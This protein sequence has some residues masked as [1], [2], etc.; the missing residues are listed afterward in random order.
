MAVQI[1]S[2]SG[3]FDE[4]VLSFEVRLVLIL[5]VLFTLFTSARR[6]FSQASDLLPSSPRR[7]GKLWPEALPHVSSPI[8]WIGHAIELR[9]RG[10]RYIHQLIL[11]APAPV[12]SINLLSRKVL[13]VHPSLERALARHVDDTSLARIISLIGQRS[14]GLSESGVDVIGA[15][16]PRPVHAQLFAAADGS[17]RLAEQSARFVREHSLRQPDEQRVLIVRWLFDAVVGAT[18]HALWGERN[19]WN[20]D[21]EFMRQFIILSDGLESLSQPFPQLTARAPHRARSFLLKRLV[22]FHQQHRQSRRTSVAHRINAVAMTDANWEDNDDYYRCELLEALGLLATASTLSVWLVRHL[23]ADDGLRRRVVDEVRSLPPDLADLKTACPHL[24]AAW[25]ETL[26]LHVTAVPRV[27]TRDIDL[28][29]APVSE[30][31]VLILPM[32][33]FNIN[34]TTWGPDAEVFRADRFL[35]EKRQLR[36][37]LTRKVRGFGV[38]GN[39]CPGRLF[40]FDTA[41]SSVATLLRDFDVLTE[42]GSA[43]LPTAKGG[44]AVGFER[45]GDDVEPRLFPGIETEGS[46]LGE[47]RIAIAASSIPI[48]FNKDDSKSNKDDDDLDEQR[49]DLAYCFPS[50]GNLLP[51]R[52]VIFHAGTVRTV[53]LALVRLSSLLVAVFFVLLIAPAY[54]KADK[55]VA[56]TAAIVVGGIVPLILITVS[57]SPFVTHIYMHLPDAARTSRQALARYVESLPASTP[58]TLTTINALAIPRYTRLRAADLRPATGSRLSRLGLVNYV[59][60]GADPRWFRGPGGFFVQPRPSTSPPAIAGAP[61]S[62]AVESWIWTSVQERIA[63]A[64]TSSTSSSSGA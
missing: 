41:M 47:A 17:A 64:A 14:L 32:L 60:R 1:L 63:R 6:F 42:S 7:Q 36:T 50:P 52:V 53:F 26:R 57:A 22:A 62:D 51:A 3:L 21:S 12:F 43:P 48:G 46:F 37:A 9:R 28:A 24:V 33:S 5:F 27:A 19:P 10:A 44:V 49:P 31:D 15:Y 18:A 2:S 30:G 8:P 11:N 34:P 38:A 58:L 35:D 59:R 16:D 25:Y 54:V 39:L 61:R 20:E 29:G 23:L 55:D 56:S 4:A 13:V 45:L 40:G